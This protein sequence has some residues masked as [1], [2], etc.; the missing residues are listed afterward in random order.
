MR[1]AGERGKGPTIPKNLREYP[2]V[3]YWVRYHVQRTIAPEVPG[4][5]S[6]MIQIATL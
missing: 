4:I 6:N 3:V 5:D 2:Q 1:D